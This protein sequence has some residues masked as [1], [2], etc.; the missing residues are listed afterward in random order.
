MNTGIAIVNMHACEDNIANTI[1]YNTDLA[2]NR[3]TEMLISAWFYGW[4]Q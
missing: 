4:L 3:I 1:F 2:T